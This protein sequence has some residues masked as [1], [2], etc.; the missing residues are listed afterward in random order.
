MSEHQVRHG[1]DEVAKGD[2]TDLD[3]ASGRACSRTPA[4]R[5][6]ARRPMQKVVVAS[7][8]HLIPYVPARHRKSRGSDQIRPG[9]ESADQRPFSGPP[10]VTE[11]ARFN[12]SRWRHGF[13]PR[14][15]Y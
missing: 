11:S 13:E 14:W 2:A 7:A 10:Q 6:V 4:A 9:T 12:L 15:D 1:V 3:R 8:T 5:P